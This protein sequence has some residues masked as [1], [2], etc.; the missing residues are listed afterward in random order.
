MDTCGFPKD[1]FYYYQAW[2]SSRPVLHLLPHWNWPGKEGQDINVCCY[3][4]C[5]EVEL[6]LNGKSHGRKP[7]PVNSHLNW[8]VKYAPGTLLACGYKGGQA[9]SE[10]KVE[11]TGAPAAIKLTAD[12]T[13]LYAGDEDVAVVTVAV[14]DDHGRIVPTAGDPINFDLTG[15][16][17]ILGVGNGDPSC[18]E[19]DTYIPAQKSHV[20]IL[21]DW[22]MK[23]VPNTRRR[24]EVRNNFDDSDWDKADAQSESG[25]LAP[26]ESAVYR[27]HFT[28][29]P[30]VMATK[31]AAIS[32]G[33]IDDDG[34]VYVNGHLVGESHDYRMSPSFEARKYIQDGENTMAIS[35]PQ[36]RRHGWIEPRRIAIDSGGTGTGPLETKCVQRA[37][38]NH[39]ASRSRSRR[40]AL[41]STGGRI[42]RDGN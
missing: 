7:M 2:W 42:D 36:P 21:H 25:P 11:T 13:S 5:E 19:P 34:W 22:K 26:G 17:R 32:V 8:T 33:M 14:V 23:Q 31:S 4:N 29:T 18:H 30:D 41:D 15:P 12:R 37:G 28:A 40:N 1:N 39:R 3:G 20:I 27:A 38:P 10:D 6:F 35:R 16:G 9:I 24:P